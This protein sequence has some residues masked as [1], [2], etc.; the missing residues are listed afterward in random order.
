MSRNTESAS[1]GGRSTAKFIRRPWTT[2]E[3]ELLTRLYED[4]STAAIAEQLRRTIGKVYQK[5]NALGLKK[6]PQYVAVYCRIQKGRQYSPGTQFK[7]GSA[8]A[9]KGV[10]RPGWSPGRMAETQ[11]RKGERQGLAVN[12]W[13]PVGTILTDSDGY[14]RVKVREA[15]AGKEATG[16]GNTK[17]WPLLSRQL[18]EQHHGPIPEKHIVAFKDGDRTN[19]VIDNLHLMSMADN[20]RRNS[21]WSQYPR[22]LAEAI[23]LAGVLKRRLKRHGEEQH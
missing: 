3:I 17:V 12:N 22:E 19:C 10:R 23:Q 16:F 2:L 21:M 14:L 1:L 4:T 9:N 13:R 8:P 18:W 11:F 5:A 6:S 15:T 20:A 7:P